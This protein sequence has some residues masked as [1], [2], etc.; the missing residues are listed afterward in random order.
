MRRFLSLLAISAA[1][2]IS[3]PLYAARSTTHTATAQHAIAATDAQIDATL[4]AKLAK[5]KIG[6]D[7]FRFRVQHGVVTWEGTT[8]VVQHKGSAT[9]MA[10]ASGAVQVVNNIQVTADGKAK[11]TSS[12][13]K[14]YVQ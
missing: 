12:L 5:S 1:L 11:A 14:A 7:G 13:K 2:S 4:R 10:R 3:V 6:K 9:R 8:S